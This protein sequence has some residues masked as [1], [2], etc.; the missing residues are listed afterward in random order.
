MKQS[1]I[2]WIGEIPDDW[3]INQLSQIVSQVK[4]KNT[5]LKENNLLSLS[6]GK[7]K[8]KNINTNDGLLPASFDGYNIISDGDI[9]L[10]LTDLQNDHTSLRVGR[11]TEQGIITSAYTT[12]HPVDYDNS[13]YLYY[14]LHS[15]DLKKGF[16][17]MGSGVRQGLNYDEVKTLKVPLPPKA[18]QQR[19]AE[20]LDSK[21]A[22]IDS[23]IEESKKS[24]EEYK[25]WKQS[26]IFEAVTGKKLNCKKKDS[27][28]EWIGE[29]PE[30]YIKTKLKYLLD[31]KGRIGFRGY[32]NADMVSEG[33]GA[34]TLSPSNLK[35]LKMDFSKKAFVSWE[36]YNE[37]PEIQIKIDDIL[38]VKTGSSYG[39]SSLVNYLP[40]EST[41]NPQLVVFKNI[42]CNKNFLIYYLQTNIIQNQ[43]ENI[44]IGGTIPTMSQEKMKNMFIFLPPLSEQESIGKMLDSKCAQ[45]DSLIAEKESLIADLTEYKKS[46]IFEVVTGKRSV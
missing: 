46:L 32:T 17:G 6:Y 19:I 1:G 31:I 41:I 16:Y 5:G 4:N 2:D 25:A 37:S 44:V 27:G 23:I 7:I 36:K 43:V 21:C 15:F 20:Y 30:K 29:I 45:I 40:I 33:E 35:N 13:K 28:I 3:K 12:L 18:T 39:K 8:R 22:Q 11:A 10:R 9:V 34:I 42:K 14:I 24:I 38:F 26:V